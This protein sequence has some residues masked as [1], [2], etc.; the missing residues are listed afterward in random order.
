MQELWLG[1]SA[2]ELQRYP[3]PVAVTMV[4]FWHTTVGRWLYENL[5]YDEWM[6]QPYYKDRYE[7]II[8][9]C[10]K[11]Q[12]LLFEITWSEVCIAAQQ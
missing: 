5:S 6:W 12:A 10:G 2:E 1:P 9:F 3:Y 7:G 8:H 11:R 4:P